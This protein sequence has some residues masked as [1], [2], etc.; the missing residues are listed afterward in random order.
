M[1][2]LLGYFRA[3][4]LP[5]GEYCLVGGASLGLRGIRS[6]E[7]HDIDILVA[8]K[9]YA[10]LTE[11]RSAYSRMRRPNSWRKS[12]KGYAT[13][14]LRYSGSVEIEAICVDAFRANTP[15]ID[16]YLT[17]AETVEGLPVISLADLVEWKTIAGRNKDARDVTI[18]LLHLRANG[19][20][21]LA[22]A[23]ETAASLGR[24]TSDGCGHADGYGP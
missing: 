20:G 6:N 22:D 9:L 5:A 24:A 17:N 15:R 10:E 4:N 13:P 11:P 3:L 8:P 19:R 14:T 16:D 18:V 1:K 7:G 23:I 2:S 12:T 21:E